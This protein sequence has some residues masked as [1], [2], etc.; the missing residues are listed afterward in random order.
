MR[1][2]RDAREAQRENQ[3]EHDQDHELVSD[4]VDAASLRL[5]ERGAQEAEDRAGRPDRHDVG[6]GDDHAER[7]R[8]QT[9]EVGP[10]EARPPDRRLEQAADPVEH[11]HV[12][13]DVQEV[14]VQ[15]RRGHQPPVVV[16]DLDVAGG[17][18]AVAE[19]PR[20]ARRPGEREHATALAEECG[21][22]DRD[23]RERDLVAASAG[24]GAS[25]A[26]ASCGARTRGSACRPGRSS[27]SPGR[28]GA[29]SSSTTPPSRDR[30]GGSRS[31]WGKPR[32]QPAGSAPR[33]RG[34][35]SVAA[36][37]GAIVG[38]RAPPSR[39]AVTSTA[40]APCRL[41]GTATVAPPALEA[42]KS[43]SVGSAFPARST[44]T[45]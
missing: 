27:C 7:A 10:D 44:Q 43:A 34:Q 25:C 14:G 28:S 33:P 42:S 21:D 20:A 3:V 8:E 39:S 36:I 29:R 35:P 16:V 15:E 11:V 4:L 12:R 17:E 30:D 40:L 24:P 26:P 5:G 13:E 38:A 6:R 18:P 32:Y 31:P 1:A 41:P 22:V 37:S 45:S 9:G 2:D 19:Q 23:Q